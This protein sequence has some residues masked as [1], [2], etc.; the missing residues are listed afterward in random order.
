MVKKQHYIVKQGRTV[1]Y[2]YDDDAVIKWLKETKFQ[3][4]KIEILEKHKL[5]DDESSY[6][7]DVELFFW[8]FETY[9]RITSYLN[10]KTPVGIIFIMPAGVKYYHR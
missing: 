9:K 2:F 6:D 3:D 5:I 8:F 4:D 7:F 1:G 10:Y